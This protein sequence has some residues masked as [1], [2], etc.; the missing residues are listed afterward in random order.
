MRYCLCYISN[1][2]VV[3][4]H[5]A[6][7][8]FLLQNLAGAILSLCEMGCLQHSSSLGKF[9]QRCLKENREMKKTTVFA[10]WEFNPNKTPALWNNVLPRSKKIPLQLQTYCEYDL[11][12]LNVNIFYLTC[13]QFILMETRVV[14]KTVCTLSFTCKVC[15][16]TAILLSCFKHTGCS[17]GWRGDRFDFRMASVTWNYEPEALSLT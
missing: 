14:N 6:K 7:L 13:C 8:D 17:S 11:H 15:L 2:S 10:L 9:S 3:A 16:F 1:S 4:L 12:F 5:L